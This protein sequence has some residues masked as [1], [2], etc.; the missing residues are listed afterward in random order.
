MSKL[1]NAA[2]AASVAVA[3]AASFAAEEEKG[4]YVGG[5]AHYTM[6]DDQKSVGT[7]NTAGSGG[8]LDPLLTSLG[9][10]AL[11]AGGTTAGTSFAT[12]ASFED[13]WGYSA[14]LGYKFSGPLRAEL[15]YRMDSNAIEDT[16]TDL[17]VESILGN[18]WYDFSL[19]ERLRPYIGGGLGMSNVE[20]GDYDDDVMSAQLGA[21]LYFHLTPRLVLDASYRYT[22]ALENPT[23]NVGGVEVE[24]EY[25][26]HNVG[27]G[28]RYNFFDAK[29]GVQDEDGDGVA[30]DAD[31]CP[32]TPAGVQV[33][34]VGCP[35][36][37]DKDG[38]ADYLDQCLNTPAGAEVDDQ[39]CELDSDNDGV[40]DANDMCPDTPAGT[41]VMS[42]GCGADQSVVLR[43]VNFETNS[44]KLTINAESILNGVAGTLNESTGFDVEL[45][46]HTDSVGNDSYNMSLS[47]KRANSV[48]NYLIG[49]GVEGNRL[50]ARG[51]GEEQPVASNDSSEGR[52][53]NR[54]VELKVLGQTEEPVMV[55]DYSA[56][57]TMVEDAAAEDVMMDE[58]E[59]TAPAADDS[60]LDEAEEEMEAA[61]EEV[62][63]VEE[64][65]DYDYNSSSDEIDYDF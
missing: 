62:E 10:G 12:E 25:S 14:I 27:L 21:G 33:D 32:G 35:L 3:S 52:A 30:D 49:Q 37:G 16:N 6:I 65:Y 39:G 38:V 1:V 5:N 45:Q 23:Y 4:L 9:L 63:E 40:V 31:Q 48:K 43:G 36:D 41:E 44:S 55:E 60:Y 29:Y 56:E 20:V 57:E 24:T 42:N 8:L 53:L 26:S 7:A 46:G 34:A 54:R 15:E 64:E 19:T 22:E 13:D 18:L 51:Y 28:L 2:L 17:D 47:K 61:E 58:A 11:A 59:I 50:V